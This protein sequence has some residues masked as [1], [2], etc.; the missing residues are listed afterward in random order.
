VI[1][2]HCGIEAP[3]RNATFYQNVGLVFGHITKSV[4]GELCKSCVHK[5]FWTF[6]LTSL[7][8]GWWSAISVWINPFLILNNFGWYLICLTMKRRPA[9][10]SR[11][12]LT[13]EA[14]GRIL[15]VSHRLLIID[16]GLPLGDNRRAKDSLN[17]W[18]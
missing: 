5:Y 8:F 11:P 12:E 18:T 13:E 4:G 10:A 2:E 7:L 15:E 1:C 3:T 9:N 16:D 6:T 14:V 17:G